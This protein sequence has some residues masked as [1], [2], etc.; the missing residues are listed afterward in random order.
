MHSTSHMLASMQTSTN[1]TANPSSNASKQALMEAYS[2]RQLKLVALLKATLSIRFQSYYP[3]WRKMCAESPKLVERD[4]HEYANQLMAFEITEK[5]FR[6]GLER[7]FEEHD[8]FRPNPVV[9]AKLCLPRPEDFGI[10]TFEQAYHEITIEA[11]K[12][13]R[14]KVEHRFSHRV[15]ELLYERDGHRQYEHGMK[16]SDFRK[17]AKQS[18][19]YW[20]HKAVRGELPEKTKRLTYIAPQDIPIERFMSGTNKKAQAGSIKSIDEL[21]KFTGLKRAV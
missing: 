8:R 10:P 2:K 14:F 18:F 15:V 16:E 4:L 1:E 21:R 7:C 9:F 19:D 20:V 6:M 13:R 17:L 12:A 5:L 11:P 3:E